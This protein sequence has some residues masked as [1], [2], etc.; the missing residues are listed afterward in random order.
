VL[1]SKPDLHAQASR[2]IL[3]AYKLVEGRGA[4]EPG[5]AQ[6]MRVVAAEL[7]TA[8]EL[9]SGQHCC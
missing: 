5:F 1:I 3:V 8:L 6:A 2:D 4:A 9:A 7:I